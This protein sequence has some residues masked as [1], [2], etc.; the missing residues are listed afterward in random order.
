MLK[1]FS[2]MKFI[3][4]LSFF[5][6]IVLPLSSQA[7]TSGSYSAIADVFAT[8]IALDEKASK[9]EVKELTEG[10][11][12]GGE[13]DAK[14]E[15][16]ITEKN[17]H[18]Q[19]L[20]L[21]IRGTF[22]DFD[23]E[24]INKKEIRFLQSKIAINA[25]RGNTLAVQR[26]KYLIARYIEQRERA[27]FI[28]YL[29]NASRDYETKE[30]ILL[31]AKKY[32][33]RVINNKNDI[34]KLPVNEGGIYVVAEKNRQDLVR[35]YLVSVDFIHY[36]L[37]NPE[38]IVVTSF[39]QRISI[40][41]A[42]SY[43]NNN[44]QFRKV[45]QLIS[46][47]KIDVGGVL[48]S[49]AIFI[50][51][52]AG[53]PL[54]SRLSQYLIGRFILDEGKVESVEVIL[55]NI[56]KPVLYLVSFFG[57]DLATNALL[58]RTAYK[59][60]VDQFS[61]IIYNLLYIS[62]IFNLIDSIISVRFEL[63]D[64][65]KQEYNKELVLLIGQVLKTIVILLSLTLVLS[66]FGIN[67]TAIISTLGIGGLAFA[68]AAKDSL[69]NFFGG[70]NI[71]IDHIFKMG[72]WIKINDAEG[73]VVEIGLRSTTIRTFDNALITV[74]NSLVSVASVVNWNRRA[75]GRRIKM[76]IGVTYESNM[77]DIRQALVDIKQMLQ[78][79]PEISSPKET[80]KKFI[81]KGRNK[82]L[83]HAD[84]QGVKTTQLVFL[85]RYNDFSIDILV[86]CFSRTVNWVEWLEVKEDVLFK[87]SD[88]LEANNLSFAYPTNV[89]INRNE[90]L[91]LKKSNSLLV[92]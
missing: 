38:G 51:T 1:I 80:N 83:S 64:K 90:E 49:L 9:N 24:K 42:I 3:R 15:K 40:I 22:S 68:M 52:L 91:E 26:D 75:V 69:S 8:V 11:V 34:K 79:H 53:Y 59:V 77:Q 62:L 86:Y 74:P 2:A 37:N 46:P 12:A 41:S 88:I 89:Q 4:L 60:S 48:V 66:H 61:F 33:N 21:M 39:L 63:V 18:F 6:I 10:T 20:L 16:L 92:E 43:V 7:A 45:N 19:Q 72:D 47:L 14:F 35:S 85:D 70:L 84:S 29:A 28:Q 81:E 27:S 36:V 5:I 55:L 87:I 76:Y 13:K 17:L 31:E 82:F 32:L 25:S 57:V 65:R 71:M 78:D 56:N 23:A 67:I 30:N 54:V 73:T 44:E 50:V 58:Y